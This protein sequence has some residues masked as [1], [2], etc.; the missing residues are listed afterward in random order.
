VA[1]VF[2]SGLIALAHAEQFA[3]TAAIIDIHLPDVSG[4]ILARE[5]RQRLGERTPIIVV[6]GDTSMEN[7]NS[8]AMAGAT[9]F[10]SK[11][12]NPAQLLDRLREW[13]R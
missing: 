13:V 2:N 4:L 10:I 1:H 6:S 9:Y 7:L 3:P 8:L 11:P 12:F 5:L